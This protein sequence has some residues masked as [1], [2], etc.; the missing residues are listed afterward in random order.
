MG[1]WAHVHLEVHLDGAIDG[2]VTLMGGTAAG[3]EGVGSFYFRQMSQVTRREK[4]RGAAA[5]LTKRPRY[6]MFFF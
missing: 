1:R 3:A 4:E 2:D 5:T 6:D